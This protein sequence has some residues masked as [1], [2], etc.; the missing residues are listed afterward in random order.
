[1]TSFT[2]EQ[3]GDLGLNIVY[4]EATNKAPLKG[5]KPKKR[6]KYERRREKSKRA[7]DKKQEAVTSAEERGP[8]NSTSE[9]VTEE[10]LTVESSDPLVN[11]LITEFMLISK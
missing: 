1:M 6:N 11:F 5:K 2:Q 10:S 7:T 9:E 8:M 3:S 4:E